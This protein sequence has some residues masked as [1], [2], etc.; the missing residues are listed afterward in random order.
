MDFSRSLIEIYHFRPPVTE[1]CAGF[2]VFSKHLKTKLEDS[3][4]LD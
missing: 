4:F 2:H 3:I 1:N